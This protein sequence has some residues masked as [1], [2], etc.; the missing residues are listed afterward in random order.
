MNQVIRRLILFLGC[1]LFSRGALVLQEPVSDQQ[2]RLRDELLLSS[3]LERPQTGQVFSYSGVIGNNAW[4][5]ALTC[6]LEEMVSTINQ[7]QL[8]VRSDPGS[9]MVVY[10]NDGDTQQTVPDDLFLQLLRNLDVD[11]RNQVARQYPDV[12]THPESERQCSLDESVLH[13]H[14]TPPR[15]VNISLSVAAPLE[16]DWVAYLQPLVI[17]SLILNGIVVFYIA[18]R[19]SARSQPQPQPTTTPLTVQSEPLS[20]VSNLVLCPSP[21]LPPSDPPTPVLIVDEPSLPHTTP[22]ATTSSPQNSPLSSPKFWAQNSSP[23]SQ[24]ASDTVS[25]QGDSLDT[26]TRSLGDES[27]GL[28]VQSSQ[29]KFQ[30]TPPT[31]S[32][33]PSGILFTAK[34]AKQNAPAQGSVESIEIVFESSHSFDRTSLTSTTKTAQD[35]DEDD[36]E[37]EESDSGNE[38]SGTDSDDEASDGDEDCDDNTNND[39]TTGSETRDNSREYHFLVCEGRYRSE[40]DEIR[41]LGRGGFGDAYEC[42]NRMTKV[43]YAIKKVPVTISRRI[44]AA[45][46]SISSDLPLREVAISA[47]LNHPHVVRYYSAWLET[48]SLPSCESNLSDEMTAG[49]TLSCTGSGQSST[50]PTSVLYIQ[51]ELCREGTLARQLGLPNRVPNQ[52]QVWAILL[53]A[54]QG[55]Q[56]IHERGFIHRD[57]KPSNIFFD[58]G[59]LKLGDFGCSRASKALAA[60]SAALEAQV[61][62]HTSLSHLTPNTASVA[63]SSGSSSLDSTQTISFDPAVPSPEHLALHPISSKTSGIGTW[64]YAAPEQINQRRYNERSDVYSLGIVLFEV[65]RSPFHT[66]SERASEFTRLRSTADVGTHVEQKFPLEAG[67]I[68]R[69][70]ATDP[71]A[72]PTVRWL[73]QEVNGWVN[74]TML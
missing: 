70:I 12:T 71:A 29:R 45:E 74:G 8:L 48:T 28:P 59:K 38:N 42:R 49:D 30:A 32:S 68:K 57:I 17:P 14:P 39:P 34:A 27:I 72:R 37:E 23:R 46:A 51:M 20:E 18:L 65:L 41:K 4:H 55:L 7:N 6:P 43:N 54:L 33:A 36:E 52:R 44:S 69:M 21:E 63:S 11:K 53:Q 50:R 62:Q 66:D 67:L 25:W 58:S 10:G 26:S 56:Y 31:R 60:A 47:S 24:A 61:N 13:P 1:I 22:P 3:R 5:L 9:S 73:I 64:V 35:D 15:Q 40:F 2:S 16:S 19:C